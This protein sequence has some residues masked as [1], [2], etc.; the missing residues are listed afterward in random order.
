MNSG[1]INLLSTRLLD[2]KI[3]IQAAGKDVFIDEIEL[4]K[5]ISICDRQLAKNISGYKLPAIFTSIHAV[6]AVLKNIHFYQPLYHINNSFCISGRTATAVE[7]E[8]IKII[9]SASS[10]SELAQRIIQSSCKEVIF[11]CGN[12]RRDELPDAL[13]KADILVHE[14][15]V[16]ETVLTPSKVDEKKYQGVLFFS[17]SAVESYFSNNLISKKVAGFCVG[18][19]TAD[20]LLNKQQDSEIIISEEPSEAGL[21][22][23]IYK[24]YNIH[25]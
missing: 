25:D 6:E 13:K 12:K 3:K 24:F 11:F 23:S 22:N 19:T 16:Y 7:H 17:P 9:D 5:T 15:V 21:L 14:I 20:A 4:I 2:E 18:K 8:R 10:A 1:K